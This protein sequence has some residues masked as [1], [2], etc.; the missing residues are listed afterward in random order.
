[1]TAR[2]NG[3]EDLDR[4][5]GKAKLEVVTGAEGSYLDALRVVNERFVRGKRDVH[6][7]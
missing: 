7:L 5:S 3:C 2:M 4:G 6:I 1:M